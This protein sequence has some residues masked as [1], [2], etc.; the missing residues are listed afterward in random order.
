MQDNTNV[1]E[2][3]PPMYKDP[4]YV[5]Y[6]T[7]LDSNI[8]HIQINHDI[9]EEYLDRYPKDLDEIL[10]NSKYAKEEIFTLYKRS[11]RDC[12]YQNLSFNV[13]INQFKNALTNT[14]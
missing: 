5:K 13:D 11:L 9:P 3:M 12:K 1:I 14:V 8:N 10:L 4:T 2:F 6:I 7:A